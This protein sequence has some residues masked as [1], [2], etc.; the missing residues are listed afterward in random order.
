MCASA[1]MA[2][3]SASRYCSPAVGGLLYLSSY[4]CAFASL[5]L[6]TFDMPC[7]RRGVTIRPMKV[8]PWVS[9]GVPATMAVP[10]R[11]HESGRTNCFDQRSVLQLRLVPPRLP[12]G[13]SPEPLQ[14]RPAPQ[15]VPLR[16]LQGSAIEG[17]SAACDGCT[18]FTRSSAGAA[19]T[20]HRWIRTLVRRERPH[21]KQREGRKTLR[22]L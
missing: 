6:L 2:K 5:S 7:A 14:G 3:A 21:E 15:R 8:T 22:H 4:R 19:A 12:V 17:R 20:S 18:G 1:A 16:Q 11:P 9:Y 10:A 13:A